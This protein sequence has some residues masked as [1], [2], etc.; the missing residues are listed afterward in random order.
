M[1]NKIDEGCV[2][3]EQ[4]NPLPATQA[5]HVSVEIPGAQLPMQLSA[6]VPGKAADDQGL[7]DYQP[8]QRPR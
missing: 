1:V 4:I 6:A 8:Y 2:V 5:S 3:V 7:G